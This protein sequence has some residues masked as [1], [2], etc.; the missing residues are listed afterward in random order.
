VKGKQIMSHSRTSITK[1]LS[2]LVNILTMHVHVI[3]KNNKPDNSSVSLEGEE[4]CR[5]PSAVPPIRHELI[6]PVEAGS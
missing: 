3:E 5:F 2:T 1:L 6:D 4:G